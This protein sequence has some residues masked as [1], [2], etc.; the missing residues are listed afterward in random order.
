MTERFLLW[1]PPPILRVSVMARRWMTALS[2]LIEAAARARGNAYAPYSGFAV[3]AAIRAEDGAV[4]AGA[5]VENAAYPQGQCAE[6]SAIGAM[7]AAGARRIREIAIIGG[8]DA[9]PS[10]RPGGAA[11]DGEPRRAAAARLRPRIPGARP[12]ELRAMLAQEIIRRKRDGGTLDDAEIAALV[13]G[14]TDG[15][16]SEGQIAAF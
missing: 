1:H 3:G 7:I 5:N 15:S 16:V 10:L 8:G 6:A 14:I 12:G 9:G 2:E 11:A 4:Y 13:R